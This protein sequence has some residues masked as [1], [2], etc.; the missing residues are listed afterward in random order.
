MS[1]EGVYLNLKYF[2]VFTKGNNAVSDIAKHGDREDPFNSALLM[3]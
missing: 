3:D 1:K 2:E